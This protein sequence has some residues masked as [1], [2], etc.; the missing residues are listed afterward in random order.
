[1][2]FLA[3]FVFLLGSFHAFAETAAPKRPNFVFVYT[4]DQRWDAIGFIQ[5]AQGDKARF[6]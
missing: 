1:M 2:K 6:P 5:K 4:D 3:C